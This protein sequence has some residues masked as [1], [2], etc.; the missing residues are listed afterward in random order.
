MMKKKSREVGGGAIFIR[1][2][3]LCVVM[4]CVH[5]GCW[6]LG[7]SVCDPRSRESGHQECAHL[8]RWSYTWTRSGGWPCSLPHGRTSHDLSERGLAGLT[9]GP[10]FACGPAVSIE[11]RSMVVVVV[12]VPGVLRIPR[13]PPRT[14]IGRA[15]GQPWKV[16]TDRPCSMDRSGKE[17]RWD[18]LSSL[19]GSLYYP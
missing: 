7:G 1:A 15:T 14:T 13:Y 11:E 10:A 6:L 12:V 19:A 9:E 16:Y 8:C 17:R 3:S 5:H 4:C 2:L 18:P